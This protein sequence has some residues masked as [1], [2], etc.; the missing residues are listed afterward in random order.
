MV[1]TS[2]A[3]CGSFDNY[4]VLYKSNFTNKDLNVDV[5]SARRLSD[6]SHYQIVKC[7][8]DGLVR[9]SPILEPEIISKLYQDSKFTYENEVANLE[10]SYLDV[11]K[12]LLNKISKKDNIL[13]IGCGNGFVLNKLYDLGFTNV[14]GVEPSV[15]A[16]QKANPKIRQ[17]ILVSILKP[18]IFKNT[19]FK[20]LFFFQT[21]DHIPNPDEFIKN[22][23]QFLEKGGYILAFNHNVESI[24]AKIL[25]EKSVII[26]IEHTFL[27]S[28]DTIKKLFEKNNFT[29]MEIFSPF[30]IVSL[31]YL[32]QLL[33]MPAL[34]KKILQKFIPKNINLRLQ[35]GNLCIIAR[36]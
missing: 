9:S 17:N 23:Y 14:F 24:S 35:L 34:L 11:L 2:C 27:Y 4:E 30:N 19:K 16:Q 22:C 36:K 18:G 3:I 13:E 26:D 10:K 32:I 29:P 6:G 1:K 28:P 25:G 31:K 8:K 7:K 12:P 20:L 5:F 15:E 21:L 33:P